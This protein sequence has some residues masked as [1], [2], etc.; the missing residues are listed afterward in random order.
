MILRLRMEME[1]DTASHSMRVIE[2]KVVDGMPTALTDPNVTRTCAGPGCTALVG[3]RANGVLA[4][5]CG[6]AC[7][8]KSRRASTFIEH[9]PAKKH[10]QPVVDA[11]TGEVLAAC[12][13][14]SSVPQLNIVPTAPL[15][16]GYSQFT[17][18]QL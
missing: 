10:R 14:R 5:F 17:F 18:P 9:Q 12:P 16:L 8:G 13:P 6:R 7:F 1:I 2:Q 4:K 11:I 3:V 15:Q